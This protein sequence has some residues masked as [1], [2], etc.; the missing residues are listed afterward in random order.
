MG[1]RANAKLAMAYRQM[2]GGVMVVLMAAV[3]L[4]G[5]GCTVTTTETSTYTISHKWP[6]TPDRQLIAE[7]M[8]NG[9]LAMNLRELS[10]PGGRVSGT[11]NAFAAE[12]YVADRC[13]AY[14][15]TNVR[16]EPFTM[17]T[18]LDDRTV[19]TVLDDP[20]WE[21]EGALSLGNCLSTPAEGL[22]AP[23]IYLNQGQPEDF[24]AAGD[25]VAGR[26]VLV[27]EGGGHRGSKMARAVEAGAAGMIQVSR[28]DDRSR[29][30][31]CHR[32]P[33][34]E[35]GL[36]IPGKP[37]KQIIERLEA[38]EE[39]RVNVLIEAKAWEASPHNVV[40]EIPGSGPHADELIL[41]TAHLDGWHLG[42]AAMDNGSGSVTILEAARA[43]ARLVKAGYWQPGRTLRFVWFMGEEHG[44]HGSKAYVEA[45]PDELDRMI[46]VINLDMPGEPRSFTTFGHTK[47]PEFFAELRADLAGYEIAEK[48]GH[49]NGFWSDHA[50]F[51]QEG[52]PAMTIS[53]ELG[54]GVKFYHSSGDTYDSV[55]TRGTLDSSA[56]L[57]VLV[58]RLADLEERPVPRGDPSAF[59]SE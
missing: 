27:R 48:V 15:L 35:P 39:M 33:R 13:R 6:D 2:R 42:E 36:A 21:V 1:K 51:M 52:V 46:M 4:S 12:R 23:L 5:T 43:L 38:G 57:A 45:H 26:I 34:P 41:I 50:P 58:R 17:T 14:G 31:Q 28:L 37:G 30:G 49:S 40:A 8:S 24:E 20:P 18:W 16:L 9:E 25:A 10:M 53:G 29:V 56:V 22:T 32:T 59:S 7:V 19:L 47:L 44:L 11:E 3:S 54:P 55:D